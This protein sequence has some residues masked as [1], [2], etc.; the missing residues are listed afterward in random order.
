ML[1]I[2]AASIWMFVVLVRRETS[3]RR[4]TALTEWAQSRGLRPARAP[5]SSESLPALAPLAAAHP[6]IDFALTGKGITIAQIRT[7]DSQVNALSS[8]RWNL[9]VRKLQHPWPATALRPTAHAVSVVDLFSLSSFPSLASN[10]RFMIFGTESQAAALLAES[11]APALLPADVGMVLSG[12]D[13]ILD[14]TSRPFDE[15]EFARM[16]DLS[17]QLITRL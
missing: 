3:Q 11:T 10:Q 7:T 5:I 12:E 16:M 13:L 14:F 9:I 6:Q 17:D 15:T 1:V 8:P 2:L 4:Q